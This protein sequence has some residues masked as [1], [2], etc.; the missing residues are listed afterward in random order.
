MTITGN[1][2][3][4]TSGDTEGGIFVNEGT[5]NLRSSIIYGNTNENCQIG[6][7]GVVSVNSNNIIGGGSSAS[8]SSNQSS[9]NPLLSANPTGSPPYY[10]FREDSP[11][12][13]AATCI[14]GVAVD[15]RGTSRPQGSLCDIGAYEGPGHPAPQQQ[16]QPNNNNPSPVNPSPVNEG[17]ASGGSGSGD[18]ESSAVDDSYS[19][20]PPSTA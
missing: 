10:T 16:Q 7:S 4:A 13:N 8:C 18:E 5:L 2:A 14:S 15:Q 6:S 19:P 3:T 20:P 9:A 12:R 11:A 17:A 1:T